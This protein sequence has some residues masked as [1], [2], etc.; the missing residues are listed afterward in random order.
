MDGSY[1]G[2][3]MNESRSWKLLMWIMHLI[4]GGPADLGAGHWAGASHHPMDLGSKYSVVLGH[5]VE[6]FWDVFG[7]CEALIRRGKGNALGWRG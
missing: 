4:E 5:M 7:D 6:E 1:R 2:Y 3:G